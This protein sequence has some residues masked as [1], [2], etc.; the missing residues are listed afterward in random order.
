MMSPMNIPIGVEKNSCSIDL[1]FSPLNHVN[2][3][4]AKEIP[5]HTD[6]TAR[7]SPVASQRRKIARRQTGVVSIFEDS[8]YPAEAQRESIQGGRTSIQATTL[9]ATIPHRH[10]HDG[11]STY[12]ASSSIPESPSIAANYK[13]TGRSSRLSGI[14]HREDAQTIYVPSE[15]SNVIATHPGWRTLSNALTISTGSGKFQ[16]QEAAQF[17]GDYGV[18]KSWKTSPENPSRGVLEPAPE[19]IQEFRA[20]H[21]RPGTGPGKENLLPEHLMSFDTCKP[22]NGH[23]RISINPPV[24][25]NYEPKLA[26]ATGVNRALYCTNSPP[27]R[28]NLKAKGDPRGLCNADSSVPTLLHRLDSERSNGKFLV[29]NLVSK[30]QILPLT[31]SLGSR[32]MYEVNRLENQESAIA[33]NINRLTD[34]ANGKWKAECDRLSCDEVKQRL[35]GFYQLPSTIELYQKL[36]TSLL[37]GSLRSPKCSQERF[38]IRKDVGF[39]KRFTRLWTDTYDLEM[40]SE[41][42][43]VVL[44]RQVN[45]DGHVQVVAQQ[46]SQS[47]RDFKNRSIQFI[48]L[49]GSELEVFQ[50]SQTSSGKAAIRPVEPR[51]HRLLLRSLMIVYL[52]DKS[53]DAGLSGNGLFQSVSKFKSSQAV[54]AELGSLLLPAIG[55]INRS[56]AHLDYQVAYEQHA[57]TGYDYRIV[58]IA[59]DL[60][61]GVRLAYFVEMV[62]LPAQRM[63]SHEASEDS[64][65][66]GTQHQVF[67]PSHE[68]PLSKQLKV[69][70]VGRAQKIYNVQITLDALQNISGLVAVR[71]KVKAEDIVDGHREKSISLLWA[72]ARKRL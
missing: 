18:T 63:T 29:P 50:L 46:S 35:L 62:V 33:R 53:A 9:E 69:P 32:Q 71:N 11:D 13:A 16:S 57:L 23:P 65:P 64:A 38:R 21:D 12:Q 45:D 8:K 52:L 67:M 2:S 6:S 44:G 10:Y 25:R 54:L 40:F 3:I 30:G 42:L 49:L 1:L 36:Q 70:C 47:P 48:D 37:H 31:D 61:D 28:H 22:G 15:S 17:I 55:N 39:R 34:V 72:L 60:R 51:W 58:N 43:E 19:T 7:V 56:L 20:N 24:P 59:T 4:P 66:Q 41:A 26:H 68:R 5:D 14:E 27:K